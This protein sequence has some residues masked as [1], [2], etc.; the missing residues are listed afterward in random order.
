MVASCTSTPEPLSGVLL[1][2][3]DL[4][5]TPD[6]VSRLHHC[7]HRAIARDPNDR[8]ASLAVFADELE[9]LV[10]DEAEPVQAVGSTP[11][12]VPRAIDWRRRVTLLVAMTALAVVIGF[13]V[14]RLLGGGL[15]A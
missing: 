5:L 2:R 13:V 11:P 1:G 14:G 8:H 15:S 3:P 10:R 12:A 7:V 9:A 6:F 4:N